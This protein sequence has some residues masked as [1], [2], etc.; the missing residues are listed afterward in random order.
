MS[1]L[2]RAAI[3]APTNYNRWLIA[4]AALAIHLCIGQV[5]A[6]SV[7]KTQLVEL[8][9]TSETAIGW[10]FSL[11]IAMLGI[12]AAVGGTWVER[13]GPR[14]S[15]LTSGTF[16]VVGF[17]VASIGVTTDQLWLVFLGY[18]FLGGIGLGLGY[19]SPVS[20]LIK[21]F[22]D[23]PGLATG[24]AIMGFGGGALIASPLS[25]QLMAT[26]SGAS[27]AAQQVS[28]VV[29][30]FLTLAGIYAVMIVIGAFVIRVPHPD[31]K[32]EGWD[33]SQVK[34]SPWRTTENVSAKTAIKTPQFWFLWIVLFTNVTAG[35]GI[36]ESAS[37]MIRDYFPQITL[38]AAAGYVGLLSLANMAGRFVWSSTSDVIGR[39]N[40]YLVYLGLGVV[41]YLLVAL[42]GHTSLIFFVLGTLII[43]SFYGGGF[44]TIPAYLRDMFGTMQ[45][46]AI[47]GRLLTA[48]SAAGIAGPLIVN[49]VLDN[50]RESNPDASGLELYQPSLLIMVG[51]LA[52]GLLAN[53]LV[54]PVN[55]K[56]HVSKEEFEKITNASKPN[57]KADGSIQVN[58]GGTL[59]TVAAWFV[60]IAVI[61]G[62]AYGLTLTVIRSLALFT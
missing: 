47:H 55:S 34:A 12:S 40:I 60:T 19:I 11:A 56:H 21:W 5:Y 27:E 52:V 1:V 32:P 4:P 29:P 53:I 49:Q 31:W 2:G 24:L 9:G 37:P 17:L 48:W 16:W 54:K 62:L 8:F 44:A 7:F 46:G 58:D 10:I 45:V 14:M 6:W 42:F 57:T 15:M 26:Y 59:H 28:G 18:G 33:P 43:L 61:S 25:N 3:V 35:I 38:A 30:T 41:L 13:V 20:T 51:V 23:R 39:K 22:P 36:L 50:V